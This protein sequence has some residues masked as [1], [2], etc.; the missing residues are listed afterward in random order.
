MDLPRSIADAAEFFRA[1]NG[2]L[3]KKL[4]WLQYLAPEHPVPL[5][6]QLKQLTELHRV[7]GLAM[8]DII[9]HLWP[10]EPIP[11]SY[12]ELVKRLVS[13]CPSWMP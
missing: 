5:S 9:I 4:F 2:S 3:T 6:D 11:G 7:G 8:R 12:F 1:E 10:A 13:A